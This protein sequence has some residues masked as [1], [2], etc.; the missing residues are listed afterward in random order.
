MVADEKAFV[1]QRESFLGDYGHTCQSWQAI[2]TMGL[3]TEVGRIFWVVKSLGSEASRMA[4]LWQDARTS[5][6]VV[7]YTCLLCALA[8]VALPASRHGLGSHY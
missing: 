1:I 7:E 5:H 6:D 2:D 8:L 4:T 3:R